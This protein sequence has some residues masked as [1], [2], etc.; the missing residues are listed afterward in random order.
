MNPGALF[1][2][3]PGRDSHQASPVWMGAHQFN[4]LIRKACD[5][6][7]AIPV[8]ERAEEGRATGGVPGSGLVDVGGDGCHFCVGHFFHLQPHL[9]HPEHTWLRQG[10]VVDV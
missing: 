1:L 10:D 7:P 9:V 6:F 2:R 3:Q 4:S 5:R 8:I